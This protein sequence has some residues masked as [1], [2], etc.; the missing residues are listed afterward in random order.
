MNTHWPRLNEHSTQRIDE[1]SPLC[2]HPRRYFGEK[3]GLYFAWLGWYTGMLIPAA[4]VGVFVFLYGLFTM[5]SSQVRSDHTPIWHIMT[6]IAQIL[7]CLA[8][9][10]DDGVTLPI[11]SGIFWRV[12]IPCL[13]SKEI[14][15]ANTT[16]MCPMCEKNCEPW[17]LS[18]SCVYAKVSAVTT[19]FLSHFMHSDTIFLGLRTQTFWKLTILLRECEYGTISILVW[20]TLKELKMICIKMMIYSRPKSTPPKS[21]ICI[22]I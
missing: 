16:I 8:I 3:I 6:Q 13:N 12:S 7:C 14:C 18:D 2:L 19:S 9:N 15:E 22:S 21:P 20:R 10:V 11:T 4:L 17:T 1:L 5:D